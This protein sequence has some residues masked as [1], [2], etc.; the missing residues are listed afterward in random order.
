[1]TQYRINTEKNG[2]EL[3]FDSIPSAATRDMLKS[4]GWRWSHFGGFWYNRNT[5]E[6]EQ[7]ARDLADGKAPTP[8]AP[9]NAPAVKKSVFTTDIVT[10]KYARGVLGY[11]KLSS[12]Q[13]IPLE[14][15]KIKTE[16]CFG[17]NGLSMDDYNSARDSSNAA[18]TKYDFFEQLQCREINHQI[19]TVEHALDAR[20]DYDNNAR[21]CFA[22]DDFVFITPNTW[23]G[24]KI[25][26]WTAYNR[27]HRPIDQAASA[28]D[29]RAILDGLKAQRDHIKK[30]SATYWKRYGGA[31]LHTWTYDIND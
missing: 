8:S 11:I 6:N 29:L 22:C 5:P 1:M 19:E 13:Y 14:R 30:A 17:Y 27:D 20:N 25:A 24:E 12:G 3:T 31:K 26:D 10:D 16:L 9:K 28:D 15:H 2:L 18:S 21:T 4:Q 7:T 23:R